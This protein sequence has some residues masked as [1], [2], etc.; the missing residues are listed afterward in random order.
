MH[1]KG[2]NALNDRPRKPRSSEVH[3]SE[4]LELCPGIAFT[5]HIDQH[6][7]ERIAQKMRLNNGRSEQHQGRSQQDHKQKVSRF[8]GK[9]LLLQSPGISR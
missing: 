7:G 5:P 8:A 6:E 2:D 4:K 3:E 1:K 9:C